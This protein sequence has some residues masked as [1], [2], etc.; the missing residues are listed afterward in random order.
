M[1][2]VEMKVGVMRDNKKTDVPMEEVQSDD[3]QIE[4]DK[5]KDVQI[6]DD[7]RK[8]VQIED[9]PK[10]DDAKKD[11]LK[12]DVPKNEPRPKIPPLKR[13]HSSSKCVQ[14][15]KDLCLGLD[16]GHF[17]QL[18]NSSGC[19]KCDGHT[20]DDSHPPRRGQLPHKKNS[21]FRQPTDHEKDQAIHS[22]THLEA[23]PT[24]NTMEEIRRYVK[25]HGKSIC[26]RTDLMGGVKGILGMPMIEQHMFEVARKVFRKPMQKCRFRPL[27]YVGRQMGEAISIVL[28]MIPCVKNK[29]DMYTYL[30]WMFM[31]MCC[32]LRKLRVMIRQIAVTYMVLTTKN[33][34]LPTCHM[35][36]GMFL[37]CDSGSIL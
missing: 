14:P 2:R 5:R 8:D 7:K 9:V 32:A 1:K 13:A 20:P 22:T 25:S 29:P 17:S 27:Y 6:E 31:R 3:V 4:D 12:L 26:R 11:V 28:D 10:K 33:R 16:L 23:Q 36:E 34:V 21:H 37:E 19:D 18:V 24:F 35:M 30:V 15:G